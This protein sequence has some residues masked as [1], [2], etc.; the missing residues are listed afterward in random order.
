[1]DPKGEPMEITQ[2]EWVKAIA[3]V[4]ARAHA[5]LAEAAMFEAADALSEDN[6]HLSDEA[7]N[8]AANVTH[9]YNGIVCRLSAI[10]KGGLNLE[11]GGQNK[12]VQ[13]RPGPSKEGAES[14]TETPQKP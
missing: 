13:R 12:S 6:K 7:I 2:E 11:H 14:E 3:L 1:M 5:I 10:L 4:E 9:I 8:A